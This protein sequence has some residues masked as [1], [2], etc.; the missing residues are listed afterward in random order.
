MNTGMDFSSTGSKCD[1]NWI[2]NNEIGSLN[3][4]Q[5]IGLI[6]LNL[7]DQSNL[8][9]Q[10][11]HIFNVRGVDNYYYGIHIDKSD[12]V[13]I[14]G[15]RIHGII[16]EG[17]GGF[18]GHGIYCDLTN[19]GTANIL[20][21]N[22]MIFDIAGDGN[23]TTLVNVPSGISLYSSTTAMGIKLYH[24][25]INL[26]RNANFGLNYA[27]TSIST[28]LYISPNVDGIWCENNIFRNHLGE[29]T[30]TAITTKSYGIY[31]LST[32]PFT[33][34]D[35]NLYDIV[36]GDESYV[37]YAQGAD[38]DLSTWQ[39]IMPE[40]NAIAKP[41][42]FVSDQDLHLLDCAGNNGTASFVGFDIDSIM[43]TYYTRGAVEQLSGPAPL[44]GNYYIGSSE[45]YHT[46]GE[47]ANALNFCGISGN[48]TFWLVD[49]TYTENAIAFFEIPGATSA[50]TVIFKPSGGV[51]PT[52]TID[53]QGEDYGIKFS[54]CAWVTFD[55]SESGNPFQMEFI[56]ENESSWGSVFKLEGNSMGSQHI[57]ILNCVI[58]ASTHNTAISGIYI[59]VGAPGYNCGYNLFSHNYIRRAAYGIQLRGKDD[60]DLNYNNFITNN[61]IGSA[62][63]DSLIST[64][65]IYLENN[66]GTIIRGNE[67]RNIK[68]PSGNAFGIASYYSKNLLFEK[69]NIHDIICESSGMVNAKGLY[70]S[71][72]HTLPNIRVHN[73]F[74]SHIT[75]QGNIA[76]NYNPA[77]IEITESLGTLSSNDVKL[78]HNSVYLTQDITYGIFQTNGFSSCLKVS[79]VS[80]GGFIDSRNNI[81]ENALGEKTGF[82]GTSEGYAVYSATNN[83]FSNSDYNIYFVINSDLNHLGFFNSSVKDD[84][85]SFK[86]S[87]GGDINSLVQDPKFISPT[88]LHIQAGWAVPGIGGIGIT[89]DIDGNSR[90]FAHRGADEKCEPSVTSDPVLTSVCEGTDT[91]FK[92]VASGTGLNYKWQEWQ[93]STWNDILDG[94]VFGGANADSLNIYAPPYTM[95]A[96]NYRCIVSNGC[97][98]DTSMG[99]MLS[100]GEAAIVDAGPDMSVCGLSAANFT[101]S[102]GGTASLVNWTTNGTGSFTLPTSLAT[103]YNPSV[104]DLSSGT[105]EVYATTDDPAGPCPAGKDTLIL[106]L[107][108]LPTAMASGPSDVCPA[109]T[110]LISGSGGISYVWSPNDGTLSDPNIPNPTVSPIVST[111]YTLEVTD[112]NGCTDIDVLP[113]NVLSPPVVDAGPNDGVCDGSSTILTGT[114]GMTTY[115]WTPAGSLST[116]TSMSTMASPTVTTTYTLTVMD[117]NGCSSFDEVTIT[118]YPLPMP[119]A[120]ADKVI[121]LGNSTSLDAGDVGT[122]NWTPATGLNSTVIQSPT[123]SPSTTT[124]YTI[125]V[126]NGFG[127]VAY[128][129]VMVTV[130]PLPPVSAGSDQATCEGVGIMLNGSGALS[131]SWTPGGGLDNPNTANPTAI[132]YGNTT[133]T[134]TG[135]DGNG[136]QNTDEVYITVN[137]VPYVDLG[138]DTTVCPGET[139][140]LDAQNPGATYYWSTFETSQFI[141]AASSGQFWVEVTNGQGCSNSDTLNIGLFSSPTV[142]LGND[143]A[144][145]QGAAFFLDAGTAVSYE[146]STLE[147]TQT[148]SPTT[149]DTYSVLITD[150]NGC[151][152]TDDITVIINPLPVV[153][154]GPDSTICEANPTMLD[155]QNP[156][157]TYAW[158]TTAST[159]TIMVNIAGYYDVT[160]TDANSC[161]AVDGMFLTVDVLPTVDA[162]ADQF[163]CPGEDAMLSGM[164]GGGASSS[165]WSSTGSG[166]FD[167]AN[168]LSTFYTPSAPDIIGG[169]VTL[170]LLTDDPAGPCPFVSDQLVVTFL[171]PTNANAGVDTSVCPGGSVQLIATGGTIYSWSPITDLSDPNIPNPIASPTATTT[172]TVTVDD[173]SGCTGSDEITVAVN[174][175]PAVDAGANA[176]ICEGDFTNLAASGADTY[177]WS[178]IQGLNDPNIA[179]PIAAPVITT[180]YTV[181]GTAA[182]GCTASDEVIITV[183]A[184]P[185]ASCGS[186]VAICFGGSTLLDGGSGSTFAWAPSAGLDNPSAQQPIAS[187]TGTTTYTVTISDGNGCSASDD[188]IVTVNSLPT[189][190]LGSDQSFCAGNF[191]SLDAGNP[192]ATFLWSTGATSQATDIYA[193]DTIWVDVTDGNGCVGTDTVVLVE[194]PLPLVDLGIDTSICTGANI[195]LDAQNAGSIFVWSDA[196][197]GQTISVGSAG[198]YWV[199]VTDGY[200]CVGSDTIIV[201]VSSALVVDLGNDTVLCS[202]STL[203]LDAQNFGAT[204][205]WSDLST[206]QTLLTSAPGTYYVD[207]D[208]GAGCIGSDTIVITGAALPTVILGG[209]TSLCDGL[210][211]TLDALN[212][213]ATYYWNNAE[214]TQ[215]ISP[216]TS[217]SYSVTVTDANGCEGSDGLIVTFIP[218]PVADLGADTALC[219]GLP[220]TLDAT[221]SGATYSWSTAE[222]SAQITPTTSGLYEVTVTDVNGCEGFDGIDVT[223]YP[224]PLVDLG[225]DTS[226]CVGASFMLDAL[227][228]GSTYYWSTLETTQTISVSSAGTYFVNV[229]EATG[230]S[231]ADTLVVSNLPALVV[232][233]GNDTTICDGGS[234]VLDA[235]NAGATYLWGGGETTQ[236]ITGSIAG[237]YSVTVTDINGCEG[238]DDIVVSVSNYSIDAGVDTLIGC[239]ATNVGLNAE[240]GAISYSWTPAA[241]LSNPTTQNPLASPTATTVYTL[242]AVNSF[243]CVATDIVQVTVFEQALADAG[244]DQTLGCGSGGILIGTPEVLG[245]TYSWNPTAG[246]SSPTIAEPTANPGATTTYT[247]TATSIDG[248]SATDVVTITVSQAPIA[249]AGADQQ[250]DCYASSV[251]IGMS[252]TAGNTYSWQPATGLSSSTA[253]R[254]TASPATTTTYTLTVTNT[255]S[256]CTA[257]DEVIVTVLAKPSSDFE[258]SADSVEINAILTLTYTGDAA[259]NSTFN[260]NVNG[261]LIVSGSGIG[262]I[263]V[264][265]TAPGDYNVCLT[266]IDSVGCNSVLTCL[267]VKVYQVVYN[268]DALF[269]TNINGHTAEFTNLSQNTSAYYWSFGDNGHSTSTASLVSHDYVNSGIFNV[270]LVALEPST[271]CQSSYCQKIAIDTAAVV[272]CYAGFTYTDL[273]SNKISF[274]S[275]GNSSNHTH[276]QWEF[277][278]GSQ[279]MTPNPV[280]NYAHGGMYNVIL[281]VVNNSTGCVDSYTK[282]ITVGT[283]VHDC[284][285]EFTFVPDD[286]SSYVS[287]FDASVSDGQITQ[288]I[289]NFDGVQMSYAKNPVFI[290]DA[291]GFYNVCLTVKGQYGCHNTTCR[292]VEVGSDGNSCYAGYVYAIDSLT[293]DVLFEDQ[294]IGNPIGWAWNFGDQT[295]STMQSPT[296]TYAQSGVFMATL[297]IVTTGGCASVFYDIV[298]TNPWFNGFRAGFGYELDTTSKSNQYPA[299]FKGAAFGDPAVISW[300]FGDGDTDSTTMNPTHVYQNTGT[301]NVCFTVSDYTSGQSDTYCEDVVITAQGFMEHSAI[302]LFEVFPNP[303]NQ[304][305][306]ILLDL[307][308]SSDLTITL[309]NIL[310]ETVSVIR[311]AEFANGRHLITFD[312]SQFANGMYYI[313]LR[314]QQTVMTRKIVFAD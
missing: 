29:R 185:T 250:I 312:R 15:N 202:G 49:E 254:P 64:Y 30:G 272:Y 278:D 110:T 74:I 104:P 239:S 163:I 53:C 86:G 183:N 195:T 263:S 62:H 251:M 94:G 23:G 6:G 275:E 55:G 77:G 52:I 271:G 249:D 179:N 218:N 84:M 97:G 89:D 215:Q 279:A 27:N 230:C 288:Y 120:G 211:L 207:V 261:G 216:V 140:P 107:N 196:T 8:K 186:D 51:T 212:P 43:R 122:Y 111:T 242:T 193:G 156:G 262:P 152:G 134:V 170:T 39:S 79:S 21:T 26:G 82:A 221:V 91:Y 303:A 290:Y 305:V 133:F 264:K 199:A 309:R 223:F 131:Y 299:D 191:V 2:A 231:G 33:S 203:L 162:G 47:A 213:G 155:A 157:A 197:S 259:S 32:N 68:A 60:V 72:N 232:N 208:N 247:V 137:S 148:I 12:S 45:T 292:V 22:N 150:V 187:P 9:I 306:N 75:S 252:A 114:A 35:Y 103:D 184:L 66:S 268:C 130:N 245:T 42:G 226:I 238:N 93:G 294:S 182:N 255:T 188:I 67:I 71:I 225:P 194:N 169:T 276:Y 165:N 105:I 48:V 253:N 31:K 109:S 11:N 248:C 115:S 160:V 265:W 142:F 283:T 78:Y 90:A 260:W 106:V 17:N 153:D 304:N 267:P 20:I 171:T 240:P 307:K 101:A 270:C 180:Y 280:H 7:S 244:P 172:Y 161:S 300:D 282:T 243:G 241:S 112:A 168:N 126:T 159:Q 164:I 311:A 146:W 205:L 289:W 144:V 217:G 274:N 235:Q 301:F 25:S 128:D 136:C 141:T 143:T 81:Y 3:A 257:S 198:T 69:N 167:Q 256:G 34:L 139:V 224:S 154:I 36:G 92:V 227:H 209:D 220:L 190:A 117:A 113:I 308:Q 176:T 83:P 201:S 178:P 5:S 63:P 24:N 65:G 121:C 210:P 54:D 18:A 277:G 98:A 192:G 158:S 266:V 76:T 73:N 269:S 174:T 219:E 99:A 234:V 173:G 166:V 4:G 285:A 181:T 189:V 297:G 287:F 87:T 302:G 151:E 286:D 41:A 88:D 59:P 14:S 119:N 284:E 57:N 281:T 206:S 228:P 147:V 291:P 16:S 296:H 108:S 28:C 118:V 85:S 80:A 214:T 149:S 204:Y 258:I 50:D 44:S 246:L 10:G 313:E 129:N 124:T 145:C 1:G 70:I 40:F 100:I 293:Q 125:Q 58:T 233:L 61:T 295:T 273:G 200:G 222:T 123:A 38:R 298:N 135:T 46:I 13:D 132:I 177:L 237:T 229:T 102:I 138:N 175:A 56:T 95:N 127:C 96:F 310:G 37:G 314:Q 19:Q 116:P 236:Q